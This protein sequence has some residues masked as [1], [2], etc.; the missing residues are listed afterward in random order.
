MKVISHFRKN[1]E[2]RL[3]KGRGPE[4]DVRKRI[5]APVPNLTLT[6]WMRRPS[7][8]SIALAAAIGIILQS[9]VLALAGVVTYRLKL[10]VNDSNPTKYG[11]PIMVV[12]NVLLSVGIFLCAFLIGESTEERIFKRKFLDEKNREAQ[13]RMIWLQ[14]GGQLMGDQSYFRRLLR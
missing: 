13:T 12:G 9:S 10:R 5:F 2:K 11:F 1:I 6:I 7:F 14:P 4:E 8:V 3:R